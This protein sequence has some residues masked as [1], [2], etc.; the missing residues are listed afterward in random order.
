MSADAGE[1]R[2]RAALERHGLQDVQPLYREL[3]VR[4]KGADPELYR[5]AVS[6]YEEEVA[7]RLERE[8]EEPLVVW[9]GYGAW[10]AARLRAGRLVAIDESG[11]A[12]TVEGDPPLGP[13]LLHL[14]DERNVPATVLAL[15]A[16]PSP[17]QGSTL[18]LLGP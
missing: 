18:E 11:L 14:P 17:A 12:E 6:R 5:R 9:V 10:L 16:D 8:G 3:L 7:P 1:R 4:L 13:L 2:Y 15:P